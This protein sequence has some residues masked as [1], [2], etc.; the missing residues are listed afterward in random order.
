MTIVPVA[1][2]PVAK[3]AGQRRGPVA[4]DAGAIAT[5][6]VAAKIAGER[7]GPVAS[8]ARPI[9]TEARTVSASLAGTIASHISG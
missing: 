9:T 6:A 7:R 4:A 2:I 5:R 8:K 3:I 1:A